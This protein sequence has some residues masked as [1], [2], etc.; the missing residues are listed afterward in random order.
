MTGW[1]QLPAGVR[2]LLTVGSVA[3]VVLGAAWGL[4]S[5]VPSGD[6]AARRRQVN[7]AIL[8]DADTRQATIDT[9]AARLTDAQ[10]NHQSLAESYEELRAQQ[11]RLVQK[12]VTQF[13]REMARSDAGNARDW[14]R[15]I[16]AL[17][18]EFAELADLD[19]I[20]LPQ[21]A[22][23]E[24]PAAP[25]ETTDAAPERSADDTPEAKPSAALVTSVPGALTFPELDQPADLSG[26]SVF[27]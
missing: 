3:T 26:Q 5:L 25:A 23:I 1:N 10:A 4:G 8:T 12:V 11:A 17:R 22:Q 19:A 2:R 18:A 24:P 13:Q 16:T 7:E 15:E 20:E 14:Q 27:R 9:L 21:A 6:D